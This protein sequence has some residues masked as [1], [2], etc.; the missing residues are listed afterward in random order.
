M[1]LIPVRYSI[2]T[3]ALIDAYCIYYPPDVFPAVWTFMEDLVARGALLAPEAVRDE[4]ELKD[5]KLLRWARGNS[6]IFADTSGALQHEAEGILKSYPSLQKLHSTR[7][8]AD[9]FVIALAVVESCSV[10]ASERRNPQNPR[11]PD[12][13]DALGIRYLRF[14]EMFR[15]EGKTF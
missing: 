5:D 4:L 1:R 9:P 6:S 11:I 15:E 2:D 3:S 12:V 13:C 10:V 7:P 14:V 8:D